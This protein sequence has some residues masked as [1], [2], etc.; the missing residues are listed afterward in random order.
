MFAYP[1]LVQKNWTLRWR[2]LLL[3]CGQSYR[4]ILLSF[5]WLF[6]ARPLYIVGFFVGVWIISKVALTSPMKPQ[7]DPMEI[8]RDLR[9]GGTC[10]YSPI[11][12]VVLLSLSNLTGATCWRMVLSGFTISLWWSKYHF[13]EDYCKVIS[14]ALTMIL[15]WEF[16]WFY[17]AIL[18]Y[19]E[20]MKPTF[21]ANDGDIKMPADDY[22]LYHCFKLC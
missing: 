16:S 7:L 20:A 3:Y 21:G 6:Q 1:W 22:C 9:Q 11:P 14:P 5:A 4:I 10:I 15:A 18:T 12:H 2:R 19:G 17:I 8:F 13:K